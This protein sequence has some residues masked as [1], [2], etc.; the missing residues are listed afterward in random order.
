MAD[1]AVIAMPYVQQSQHTFVKPKKFCF[2]KAHN[3]F[4]FSAQMSTGSTLLFMI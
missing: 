1:W 2:R 3:L 4:I